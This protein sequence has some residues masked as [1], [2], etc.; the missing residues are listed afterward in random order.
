MATP[1]CF[2]GYVMDTF[3]INRR[4]LLDNPSVVSLEGPEEHSVH[5]LVDVESCRADGYE[6]LIDAA[7]Y[8]AGGGLNC[9][10]F[11]LDD[12]GDNL[13]LALARTEGSG[14]CS[15]CTGGGQNRN[16]GFRATV[17]GEVGSGS[18]ARLATSAVY[19]DTTTCADLGI[20]TDPSSLP[21]PNCDD[22]N[23]A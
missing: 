22:D 4:T 14:G 11:Q 10:Q 17:V 6:V 8:A 12:A 2:T 1:I 13:V 21:V 7:D 3:C 9:R 15:T 23:L 18:P 20:S 5:C 19:P 16:K